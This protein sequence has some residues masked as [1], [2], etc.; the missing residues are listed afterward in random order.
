MITKPVPPTIDPSNPWA[1]DIFGRQEDGEILGQIAMGCI[2]QPVSISLLGRWGSG[3]TVFL[4][5]F[6]AHMN[7]AHR[8]KCIVIDAWKSDHHG[9]P[10]TPILAQLVDAIDAVRDVSGISSKA[11]LISRLADL[12]SKYILPGAAV[13]AD[14]AAPGSGSGA[15]GAGALARTALEAQCDRNR[16]E[17]TFRSVLEE[18]RD[19]IAR[20]TPG[21]PIR[22]I[23]FVIDELDRCRPSYGIQ[24]L[25]RIKHYFD[26]KGVVFLIATDHGNLPSAVKTVYGTHVDGEEYLRKFFDY[27]FHLKA[28][29]PK[30]L[31]QHLVQR[32]FGIDATKDLSE[33]TLVKLARAQPLTTAELELLTH[34]DYAYHFTSF[35][36]LFRLSARD[37]VQAFTIISGFV[38]ARRGATTLPFVDCFVACARFGCNSLFIGLVDHGTVRIE[39]NEELKTKR[40]DLGWRTPMLQQFF[41]R[42][43]ARDQDE[44]GPYAN[45]F[46]RIVQR[47]MHASKNWRKDYE[48]LTGLSMSVRLTLLA[49]LTEPHPYIAQLIRLSELIKPVVDPEVLE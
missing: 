13:A 26:I 23:V 29:S 43:A 41:A 12:G 20:R 27:Q 1:D 19:A 11:G 40:I 25:E 36:E 2:D 18:A 46:F 3:K 21:G 8:V 10:L 31:A 6:V 37:Q 5:R 35:S 45:T 33:E 14:I 17:A 28:A 47:T 22:P 39:L 34:A 16:R 7:N 42:T 49:E 30:A 15:A 4:E 44:P 32:E 9:D 24:L 38:R 48:V